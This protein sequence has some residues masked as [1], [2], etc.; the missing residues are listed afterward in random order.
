LKAILFDFGGVI[1]DLKRKE[2]INVPVALSKLFNMS[3]EQAVNMWRNE[4][5]NVV[6]GKETPKEFLERCRTQ[7][8]SR[9]PILKLL[10]NWAVMSRKERKDI[11]WKL[12][13]FVRKLRQ[14]VK[15]YV[16]S[17]TIDLAQDDELSKE[18]YSMFDGCFV[19]F[20]EG[21]KKPDRE[22]FLHVLKKIDCKPE[23]CVFVDDTE[24]NVEAAKSLGI[25]AIHYIDMAQLINEL[26]TLG[27]DV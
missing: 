23:E 3:L 12:L 24:R 2:T 11:D 20:R 5:D 13:R 10:K 16:M 15:A 21:Y 17:D 26:N 4:R 25:H 6:I 9:V 27:L 7:T 22:A 1:L 19:S 18:V 14:A 8:G